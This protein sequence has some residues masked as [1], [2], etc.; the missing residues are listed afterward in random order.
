MPARKTW[1]LISLDILFR[2]SKETGNIFFTSNV[3]NGIQGADI[4][5]RKG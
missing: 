4:I 2:S 5:M 3:I 1:F